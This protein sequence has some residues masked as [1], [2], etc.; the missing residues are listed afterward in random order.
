MIITFLVKKHVYIFLSSVMINN[1]YGCYINLIPWKIAELLL[2]G[3]YRLSQEV[4]KSY[5]H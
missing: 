5:S 1:V 2:Y 3:L 4:S